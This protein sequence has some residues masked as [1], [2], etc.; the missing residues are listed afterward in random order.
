M[1]GWEQFL[2]E[3]FFYSEIK[4]KLQFY[5]ANK[6][7]SKKPGFYLVYW[8]YT[9]HLRKERERHYKVDIHSFIHSFIISPI[10]NVPYRP[11]YALQ[12]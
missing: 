2:N 3:L 10:M 11:I 9:T 1:R 8:R 5:L 4:E 7:Y 6:T 12:T